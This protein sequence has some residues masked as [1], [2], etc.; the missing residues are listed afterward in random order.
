MK[1]FVRFHFIKTVDLCNC[2]KN[3]CIIEACVT[4]STSDSGLPFCFF[5][6]FKQRLDLCAGDGGN[7]RR[8]AEARL[9]L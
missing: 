4:F 3:K 7:V 2:P 5:S 9:L 6:H 8:A 1:V